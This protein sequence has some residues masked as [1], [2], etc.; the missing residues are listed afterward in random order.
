MYHMCAIV[1]P[2]SWPYMSV[3]NF[4]SKCLPGDFT[5]DAGQF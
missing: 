4:E 1:D 3:H 2:N 5:C